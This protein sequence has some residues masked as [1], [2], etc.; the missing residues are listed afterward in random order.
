[1]NKTKSEFQK[2]YSTHLLNL[3]K[4]EKI[5]VL[6][7]GNLQ[8]DAALECGGIPRGRITEVYGNES[9]GKST[10]ALEMIK[11][12]QSND[13][14]VLFIDV[15]GSVDPNY[16]NN[17]GISLDKLLVAQPTSGE[18]VF[19]MIE[20]ALVDDLFDLIIID[21]VAAMMSIV[22]QD[23]K[24]QDPSLL[25]AHARMM[26]RG[27]RKI[28]TLMYKSKTA[29][30]FINQIREKIG[31]YFGN[32][33]VTTGGKALRFFATIRMEVKKVD[34]I[35]QGTEKIGIK[36]KITIT[37]NKLGKPYNYAHINIYFNEGFDYTK[38][39]TDFALSKEIIIRKGAWFY[40]NEIKIGQGT[41][42]VYKFLN[43]NPEILKE[44]ENKL[45]LNNNDN[46]IEE[47]NI[48]NAINI[49]QN[50]SIE[51]VI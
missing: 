6:S 50:N 47:N 17:L 43:D 20:D 51:Q 44:I 16:L 48:D 24:F 22:E 32:P 12:C 11:S 7:T 27:L 35:K 5:E 18:L 19:Q 31:V 49:S 36:S 37:K 25:G 15:E 1:M 29:I 8:L 26:S 3:D 9:S 4:N 21:S 28:Q 34:L 14:K 33:E 38:D 10:L 45:S 42:S 23:V 46:N 41:N 39:I 2:N 40:Y 13:G 30:V